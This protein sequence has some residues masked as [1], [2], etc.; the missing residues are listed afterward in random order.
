MI[1]AIQRK[2]V[3]G[4]SLYVLILLSFIACVLEVIPGELWGFT[5]DLTRD[6]SDVVKAYLRLDSKGVR[7][8]AISQETLRPY[9]DWSEEPTWAKVIVMKQFEVI[10]DVEKW[11]I[12]N[13]L[14]M[15]I[16]VTYEVVG[17]LY[18]ETGAFVEGRHTERAW[19]HVKGFED[20]W[21]IIAPQIPP[22]VKVKR[23]VNIVR[24]AILE[25]SVPQ[26]KDIL[27]S[28]REELERMKE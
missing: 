25:E 11:E 6:P 2:Q 14:E 1:R 5:G 7:L 12:I 20:R 4:R 16:P 8:E 22:H 21:R 19:F 10:E 28:L 13:S 3:H 24:Q 9:I 23:M 17:T 26:R 27:V 18:W 15:R